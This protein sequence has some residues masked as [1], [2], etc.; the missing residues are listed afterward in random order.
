[1]GPPTNAEIVSYLT[2]N[3]KMLSSELISHFKKR[4][5]NKEQQA[6]FLKAVKAVA[7]LESEAGKKFVVLK[8]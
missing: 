5:K 7:K 6:A 8:E 4:L 1:M 2:E 3:G